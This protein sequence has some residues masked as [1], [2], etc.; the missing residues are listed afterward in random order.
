M[1]SFNTGMLGLSKSHFFPKQLEA[2]GDSINFTSLK[3]D[4]PS[5]PIPSFSCSSGDFEPV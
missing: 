2:G 1:S 4:I 3:Y 5:P